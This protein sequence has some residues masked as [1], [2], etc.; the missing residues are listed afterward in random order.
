[1][2]PYGNVNA[3]KIQTLHKYY[4]L[5]FLSPV[6]IVSTTCLSWTFCKKWCFA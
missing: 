2:P 5:Y 1:M 4:L 3:S 6:D